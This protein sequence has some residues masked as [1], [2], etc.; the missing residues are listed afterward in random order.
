M[1]Y[2]SLC[3]VPVSHCI[4]GLCYI[5][6]SSPLGSGQV[7]VSKLSQMLLYQAHTM[8]W[9]RLIHF[10]FIAYGQGLWICDLIRWLDGITPFKEW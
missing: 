7:L 8:L 6:S 2:D 5:L 10:W 9:E 3:A 4:T 1:Q